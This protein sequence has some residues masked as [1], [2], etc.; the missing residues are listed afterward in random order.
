MAFRQVV[1]GHGYLLA[2]TT[3][4]E[5][6]TGPTGF[7]VGG[8]LGAED[9]SAEVLARLLEGTWQRVLS[10]DV[11]VVE[12]MRGVEAH[13]GVRVLP[14]GFEAGGPVL[15]ADVL[16]PGARVCFS[17]TVHSPRHGWLE[18]EELHAMAEARGLVAV[19]TLTK[20][21]TD[22]LVVAEAGSQST[23]AKNAA[24]WEKPV[25]TA[26]EFLEWVG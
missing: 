22:V 20:T 3:G 17:G 24:K 16:V 8:N 6:T 11:E 14:D 2:R 1:T 26:E 13:F 12:R 18:K 5:G 10:P 21:R 19:P 23:K 4:A 25:V 7:V 15:A 9:D